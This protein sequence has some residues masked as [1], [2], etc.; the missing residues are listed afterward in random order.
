MILGRWNVP[1]IDVPGKAV[2]GML[3]DCCTWVGI[4][5]S[6]VC[7]GGVQSKVSLEGRAIKRSIHPFFQ[8]FGNS[9]MQTVR[10]IPVTF[11]DEFSCMICIDVDSATSAAV[12]FNNITQGVATSIQVVAAKSEGSKGN[13]AEWIVERTD[14]ANGSRPLARFDTVH[15]TNAVVATAELATVVNVGDGQLIDMKENGS[16]VAKG[17]PISSTSIDVNYTGLA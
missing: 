16:I 13:Q 5:D 15:F 3:Y 14:A 6:D 17:E 7:Q 12:L 1:Y 11:G 10:G 8:W 4:D 2:E 9:P